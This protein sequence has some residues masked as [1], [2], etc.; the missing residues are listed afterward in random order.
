M[1]D[2]IWASDPVLPEHPLELLR[3]K[4]IYDVPMIVSFVTSEGLY[5]GA[6]KQNYDSLK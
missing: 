4:Q 1:V 2:G 5:P 3:K 6:G